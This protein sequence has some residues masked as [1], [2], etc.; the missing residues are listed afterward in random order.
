LINNYKII[1]AI[2]KFISIKLAQIEKLIIRK[3]YKINFKI[4]FNIKI[5]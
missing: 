1:K 4:Q 3:C 5:S 2:I